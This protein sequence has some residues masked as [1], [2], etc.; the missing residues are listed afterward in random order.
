MSA[1]DVHAFGIEI[2]FKQLEKDGWHIESADVFANKTES[3]QIIAK[4]DDER[5]FFVV[6][7][8]IYPDR[9]RFEEGQQ[10]FDHLVNLA[11]ANGANCYFASVGIANAEAETEAEMS[12]AV[13]G[14]PF[15]VVFD[16]LIKMELP[17]TERNGNS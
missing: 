11:R 1:D 4:K 8:A 9:G 7:T 16:G 17:P 13:K 3:P 10:A 12:V 14:A 2:V 5:A 6:R 15:N